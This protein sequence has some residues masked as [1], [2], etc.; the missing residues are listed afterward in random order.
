MTQNLLAEADLAPSDKRGRDLIKV[1]DASSI[2]AFTDAAGIITD[3][4]DRFCEISKYSRSELLGKNHRMINS[5]IHS[6]EF[7][8][9]FWKSIST[10]KIWK[11]EIRNRAKDGSFYWLFTT[12]VPLQDKFGNPHQ[13]V[14]IRHDITEFKKLELENYQSKF[15]IERLK[16]GQESGEKFVSMLAHDLRTPLT[17]AK[18]SAEIILRQPELSTRISTLASSTV[19]GIERTENMI[20]HLLDANKIRAGEILPTETIDCDFGKEIR[21]T[22]E[23]L[24]VIYG[25]RFTYNAK[26]KLTGRWDQ[27]GVRRITENL[28]S[29]AIKYGSPKKPI[30]VEVSGDDHQ[31]TLSV[32]NDGKLLSAEEQKNIFRYMH[33]SSSA[34][35]GSSRGWGIG[36]AKVREV[37]ES[38]GGTVQ[39]ESTQ[40]TGTKFTV[41]LPRHVENG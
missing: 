4:N 13:Y 19:R 20:C 27:L 30:S 22:L 33:R 28:C 41:R 7:W 40:L 10:G 14:S 36:L 9:T 38:N 12:V 25:E 15:E 23:V 16:L 29:N 32:C 5:G 11:G 26:G 34:S 17:A 31:V 21:I 24:R 35:A 2:V 37:A 3:V 18:L 1:L 8:N 6:S 39:V